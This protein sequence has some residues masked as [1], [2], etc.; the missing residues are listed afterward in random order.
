[1]AS[2]RKYVTKQGKPRYYVRYR[3]LDGNSREEVCRTAAE[4][5]GRVH[6][7]EVDKHRGSWIDPK[8]TAQPFS[9]VAAAWL[10]SNP[11]KRSSTLARDRTILDKHVLPT[12][13]N[14]AIGS[15]Q[16]R[17]VQALV[18]GWC[19]HLAPS[20]VQRNYDVVHAVFSYA[21]DE[22]YIARSP[23]RRIKLPQAHSKRRH[24]VSADELALLAEALG[25][26]FA[27]MAYLGAVLGLR[28][29][30]CAGLRVGRLNFFDRTIE[31][32]E[33]ITRGEHGRHVAGEPKSDAGRRV[34]S[35]PVW[36]MDLFTAH[37]ARR[38]ITGADADEY[39]F[40][41]PEGGSL[42]YSHWRR[43]YWGPAVEQAG[44][45]GLTF[46]DLRRAASTALV[47]EGVDLKTAQTRLG[48]TDVRLTVGL[49]AQ[50]STE[51]DRKAAEQVGDRYAPGRAR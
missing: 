15:T 6:E 18:N 13:G 20:T 42:D 44:L 41:M 39:V 4:A 27:P 11:K 48:H 37:L 35:A 43:R 30:E 36:L 51:A 25:P 7:L 28:W 17:D 22:D 12:I 16:P 45:D 23:C 47:L 46:H 29:G 5:R 2:I 40:T 34:L 1:M 38:G 32:A 31:V 19:E 24:I 49:Y 10:T 21:V 3:D 50:A 33:Q 26:D 8:R 14:H 9:E